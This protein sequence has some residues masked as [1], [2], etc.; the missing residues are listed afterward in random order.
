MR[1]I[2]LQACLLIQR[3]TQATCEP[4]NGQEEIPTSQKTT[5]REYSTIELMELTTVLKKRGKNGR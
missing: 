2:I 1:K 3:N 4:G 5:M